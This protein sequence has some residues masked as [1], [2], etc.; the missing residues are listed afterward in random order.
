[1]HG[2]YLGVVRILV[3]DDEEI[4]RDK[5]ANLLSDYG[6]CTEAANGSAALCQFGFAH[7]SGRP[8]DLITMD[9]DMPDLRGHE[10]V[11]AMRNWEDRSDHGAG[12]K[13]AA[14]VMLS[15]MTSG[16]AIFE[17]FKQAC[18]DYIVKPI[19]PA[20]VRDCIAKLGIVGLVAGKGLA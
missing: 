19:T 7:G 20:K 16:D 11:Q 4:S 13:K 17:A 12:D 3:V 2:R 1:M 14:I 8:F 10:V 6:D 9:I 15:S 18:D 5:V